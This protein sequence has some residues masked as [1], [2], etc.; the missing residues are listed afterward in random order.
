VG[1]G[2]DLVRAEA[3][4]WCRY[5][6]HTSLVK[7][8]LYFSEADWL[9][10]ENPR[11]PGQPLG[12]LLTQAITTSCGSLDLK[13]RER[14]QRLALRFDAFDLL[15]WHDLRDDP[16]TVGFDT[17]RR[18]LSVGAH[19]DELAIR[20]IALAYARSPLLPEIESLLRHRPKA[21]R[22]AFEHER[23]RRSVA[24]S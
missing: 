6:S 10:S 19:L 7:G 15:L 20:T 11:Q 24:E 8:L 23:Q 13:Q 18:F 16:N 5:K 3:L 17:L 2:P 21:L 4:S 14:L 1:I 12:R 9:A 22:A